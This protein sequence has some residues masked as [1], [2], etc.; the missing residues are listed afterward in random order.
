LEYNTVDIKN[1]KADAY[2]TR[3]AQDMKAYGKE[4][5]LR[6]LHEANGDWY[7]WAIGYSSRVNTNE[8]YIAA[9]RHIVDISVPT[10][11]QRQMGV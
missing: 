1:G 9:F 11:H 4:I 8:T 5:W 2:I 3:M 6:P 7:P 10:E